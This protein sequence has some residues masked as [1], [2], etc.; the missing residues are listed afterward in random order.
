MAATYSPVSFS[1]FCK[2]LT[3]KAVTHLIV[4]SFVISI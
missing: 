2:D 4:H 3:G 1:L